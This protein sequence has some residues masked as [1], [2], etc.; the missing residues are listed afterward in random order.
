MIFK[1]ASRPPGFF[2]FFTRRHFSVNS[3]LL[4][5]DTAGWI[6][7][8]SVRCQHQEFGPSCLC[9]M[10]IEPRSSH[11]QPASA[12]WLGGRLIIEKWLQRLC[13]RESI[14]QFASGAVLTDRRFGH[15]R[16]R[17]DLFRPCWYFFLASQLGEPGMDLFAWF[18]TPLSPG[19]LLCLRLPD[20]LGKRSGHEIK[21]WF[22]AFEHV[23]SYL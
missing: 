19:P 13:A 21:F 12:E 3:R 8:S 14:L 4:K 1:I 16:D 18:A 9:H 5:Q 23:V 22:S 17:P 6:S 20:P 10:Q 15:R 2:S 7:V 11:S